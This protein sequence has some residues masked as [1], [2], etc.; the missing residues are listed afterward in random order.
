MTLAE[1]ASI[2]TQAIVTDAALAQAKSVDEELAILE[3]DLID[4]SQ[5]IVDIYSRYIFESEVFQRREQSE[6]S[7]DDFCEIMTRAQKETY[8]EA[9]DPE[10]LHPYMWTWKSHY[11]IP[12]LSFY[13]FPYAF[14]LLFGLGLYAIYQQR[15]SDFLDEYDA[16]LSS[17][18]EGTAADLAA[19]FDINLKEPAFWEGSLKVIEG[20]ID[21]YVA[22]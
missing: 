20:R 21:R 18:G 1:T 9:L 12:S 17:T 11:Y 10:H 2:F 13:N 5:V 22:L 7:A 14:G 6:L 19:R 8:A 4:A 3:T 15:G 16:L